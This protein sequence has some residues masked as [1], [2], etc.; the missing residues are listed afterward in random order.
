MLLKCLQVRHNDAI[1]QGLSH[2][3]ASAADWEKQA[4]ENLQLMNQ[5]KGMLEETASWQAQTHEQQD[6]SNASQPRPEG[7]A[8]N[9]K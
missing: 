7:K 4:Q 1:V 5:L 2:A 9:L 6:S 8:T 3:Q